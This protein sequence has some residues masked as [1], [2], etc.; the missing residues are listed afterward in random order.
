MTTRRR[1]IRGGGEEGPEKMGRWREREREE[2]EEGQ[3][4][5]RARRKKKQN[6]QMAKGLCIATD[7]EGRKQGR[8]GEGGES[9]DA[10]VDSVTG[11]SWAP[12]C[13][14]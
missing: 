4:R 14:C 9:L 1:I 8:K 10:T 13:A 11:C 2:E 12:L 7:R 5:K 6:T 3:A